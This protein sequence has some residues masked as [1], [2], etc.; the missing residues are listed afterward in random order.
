VEANEDLLIICI[1]LELADIAIFSASSLDIILLTT[2]IGSAANE[3]PD[4]AVSISFFEAEYGDWAYKPCTIVIP[5]SLS[6]G[7]GACPNE[8][9]RH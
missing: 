5:G 4:A 1:I 7:I 8:K 2:A 3:K 6:T 9:Y